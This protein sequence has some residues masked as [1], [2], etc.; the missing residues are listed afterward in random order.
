MHIEVY[1]RMKSTES[2]LCFVAAQTSVNIVTKQ[3][4][5]PGLELSLRVLSVPV[6]VSSGCSG[7]PSVQRHAG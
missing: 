5:R 6:K 7:P 2:V 3:Q 4:E 1:V